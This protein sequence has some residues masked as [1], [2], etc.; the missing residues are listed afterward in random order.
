MS[1]PAKKRKLNDEEVENLQN[2]LEKVQ[3]ELVNVKRDFNRNSLQTI[4]EY[5]DFN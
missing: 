3:E 4:L 5:R 2:E 1:E